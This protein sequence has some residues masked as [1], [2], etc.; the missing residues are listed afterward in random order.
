MGPS[1]R[2]ITLLAVV[3]LVATALLTLLPGSP[4]PYR[5]IADAVSPWIGPRRVAFILNVTLFVPLGALAAWR[6][7]RRAFV[8]VLALSL[9]IETLQLVIPGRSPDP[10]DLLANGVGAVTG[11]YLVRTLQPAPGQP[12]R[13][14]AS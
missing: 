3:A 10:F 4:V 11:A 12:L 9:L 5:L 1:S 6:R 13:S 7:S 14:E 8:A 2:T